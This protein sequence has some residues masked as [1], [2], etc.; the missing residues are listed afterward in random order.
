MNYDPLQSSMFSYGSQVYGT[1]HATSDTDCVIVNPTFP[2]DVDG[3]ETPDSL[4]NTHLYREDT[5]Q[6]MLDDHHVVA[7][8]CWLNPNSYV[9]S[10]SNLT[11]TL[12]PSKLRQSFSATASNSWVK[13]KKKM[14]RNLPSTYNLYVGQKSAWHALRILMFAADLIKQGDINYQVAN[15]YYDD[16]MTMQT[17]DEISNKYK[18]L[19]NQFKSE[20]RL[21]APL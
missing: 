19:Y 8:E 10:S 15:C 3:T 16:I 1:S 18:T 17:F 14:D 9:N 6:K 5:F 7:V 11:F 4:I 20:L 13:A 21:L 2:D 12:D